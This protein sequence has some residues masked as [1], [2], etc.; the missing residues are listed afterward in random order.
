MKETFINLQKRRLAAALRDIH[1]Q[2]NKIKSQLSEQERNEFESWY[3]SIRLNNNFVFYPA[4]HRSV[5]VLDKYPTNPPPKPK[6]TRETVTKMET[7]E[8]IAK[9]D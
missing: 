7:Y 2:F 3:Y 8:T 9:V 1:N 4:E 6:P 5:E